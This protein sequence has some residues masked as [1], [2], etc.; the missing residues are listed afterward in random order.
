MKRAVARIVG[1]YMAI[2]SYP[3]FVHAGEWP[4][5]TLESFDACMS[6]MLESKKPTEVLCFHRLLLE[7]GK[8]SS[9]FGADR[10]S[11]CYDRRFSDFK[12]IIFHS[13]ATEGDVPTRPILKQAY[14]RL[15]DRYTA[16]CIEDGRAGRNL[17]RCMFS[18]TFDAALD[19]RSKA[20]DK[21]K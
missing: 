18:P 15:I 2:L 7:C 4:P 1:A 11:D 10:A 12:K 9:L 3:A 17:G 19:L 13:L 21:R 6:E 14:E 8:E 5:I 20:L 16:E